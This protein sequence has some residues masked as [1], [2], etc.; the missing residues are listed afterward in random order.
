MPIT[1][2]DYAGPADQALMRALVLGVRHANLH[3]VDL[4]YRLSSWAL[5]DPRN[6]HL[7]FE[8]SRLVGWAVLQAPFWTVD[9]GRSSGPADLALA[10]VMLDWALTRAAAVRGTP[11]ARPAWFVNAFADQAAERQALEAAGFTDAAG[12]PA[13]YYRSQGLEPWSMVQ[14]ERPG[15]LPVPDYPLR[16]ETVLR[17]LDGEG[18]AAAY[19]D[20]HQAVFASKNMT[21]PWRQAVLRQP[22]YSPP[23]DVVAVHAG[24]LA[25]FCVGWL[26]SAAAPGA[27]PILTGQIEPLGC[28]AEFRR[29]A[30]GRAALAE[31]LRRLQARGAQKVLVQTDSFRS[32]A[33][34]LYESLGFQVTRDIRVYRK[35]LD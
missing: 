14:L 7:W 32:T 22:G 23:L 28:G 11:H 1:S 12:Q 17:P 8:G 27:D 29:F 31:V 19:V 35:D 20:L 21:L 10:S 34:D 3:V 9:F 25:A 30:L 5:D 6:A 26:A 16:A 2:R 13:E 4:P 18:E 33:R 15:N 24:R